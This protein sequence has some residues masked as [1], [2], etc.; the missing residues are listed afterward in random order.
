M[1]LSHEKTLEW[2]KAN[3]AWRLAKKTKPIWARPVLPEEIGKEFKTAD[4]PP[5][6]D[7]T[8]KAQEGFWLCV[9]IAGEPWF[10]KPDR[11]T[12][13]YNAGQEASKQFSFDTQARTYRQYT[14]KEDARNWAA[15][16]NVPGIAGFEIRPKYDMEH[17]LYSPAGGYVV[18]DH[19]PDPY[20][21]D[22][23]D[24]WLVQEALFN[25]TYEL[26]DV[27]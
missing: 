23:K 4:H 12:N 11:V 27:K 14:P 26:L 15:Q 6:K 3:K 22:P 13:R 7:V 20:K 9:G 8:E 25:S 16:V 2:I 17:P 18:M 1:T 21:A 19:V 24:V 5:G 10:Q